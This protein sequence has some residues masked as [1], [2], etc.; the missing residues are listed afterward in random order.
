[1]DEQLKQ[2][3]TARDTWLR[4]F[5]IVLFTVIYTVAEIILVA[6]V[7]FQFLATLITGARNERLVTLGQSLSTFVY[8]ILRYVT[9]NSDIRPYPFSAWP[10][11]EPVAEG[12][13]KPKARRTRKKA[14][15]PEDKP[16]TQAE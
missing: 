13:V 16:A 7:V 14:A 4:G 3:L 6:V 9:F 8:Q 2:H 10:K 11:G 15:P 12:S 5:Y 1:M